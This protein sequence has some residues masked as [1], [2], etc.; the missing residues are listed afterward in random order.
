MTTVTVLALNLI[1]LYAS[2]YNVLHEKHI[3]NILICLDFIY[4]LPH[5]PIR[6]YYVMSFK[7]CIKIFMNKICLNLN[8]TPFF[9]GKYRH[10]ITVKYDKH[11]NNLHLKTFN[12]KPKISFRGGCQRR[13]VVVKPA[14]TMID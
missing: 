9:P 5:H 7:M 13:T 3:K 12:T 11:I 8:I 10:N 2:V 4:L 1:L 6:N 14:Q